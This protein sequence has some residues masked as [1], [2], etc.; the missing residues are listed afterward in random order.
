M[1]YFARF[2]APVAIATVLGPFL[3]GLLFFLLTLATVVVDGMGGLVI[4][5]MLKIFAVYVAFAYMEGAKIAAVAGVLLA[6]WMVRRPSGLLAANGAA[7]AAVALFRVAAEA[8][9]LNE[10]DA[11]ALRNNFVLYILLAA[12]AASASWAVTLPWAKQ[13]Q[14]A[15]GGRS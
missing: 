13:L 1:T 9:V 5:E 11:G 8:N 12:F 15:P 6:V 10:A 7:L 4:T 14:S 2:L 3:A